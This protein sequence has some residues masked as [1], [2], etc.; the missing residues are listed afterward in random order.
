MKKLKISI[1]FL[2]NLSFCLLSGK[3]ISSAL[4]QKFSTEMQDRF[5]K[6]IT[7]DLR[8]MDIIDVFKFISMKGD[9]SIVIS[10]TVTG[11]ATLVLKSVKIVDAM[12]I[13]CIANGL[14]YRAMENIVYVM[15][16]EEYFEMYGTYFRDK[17]MVKIVYLQYVRPSYAL[18]ALKNVKSEVGKLV[19]DED[20][21]AIVMID[22][23]DK[24]EEMQDVL[25]KIDHKLVTKIFTIN[26]ANPEEVKEKLR[27]R[28][29]VKSVGTIEA[30]SR[31]SQVIITALPSRFD[32]IEPIIQALDK[33]TKE[34]MI[35]LKILKVVLN[36]KFDFGI[37][38]DNLLNNLG[39]LAISGAFPI[40]ASTIGTAVGTLAW[41]NLDSDKFAVELKALKQV[42]DVKTLSNPTLLVTN[43]EEAKIHIGDKLAYVT[44]TTTGTGADQTTNEEVHFIDVGILLTVQPQI[45]DDGFIR[46][47]ISPEI[48]SKTSELI[49]PQGAEIPIVN[50][51]LIE[52]NVMVKDGVSIIIGGLHK[53]EQE[54]SKQGI[55]YLMDL[56]FVGN[57]FKN[58]SDD[59]RKTEIVIILTPEIVTGGKTKVDYTPELLPMKKY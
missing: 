46:M 56:P 30:D 29:D 32:E 47:K 23:P 5:S 33:Q 54:S 58:I 4:N 28:L 39:S 2:L 7:L 41:G 11:R 31:S 27:E 42:V 10:K 49:T 20:S 3:D 40:N 36:P 16:E 6:E 38:W 59:I 12:D 48:S 52:T 51:T 43:N 26:Y 24:V 9:F 50:T 17:T 1:I 15:P 35:K 19:I 25:D 13:I 14:G 18:E 37:D 22:T 57:A 45:G 44:T 34:V 55:P 21:G 53:D 8:D